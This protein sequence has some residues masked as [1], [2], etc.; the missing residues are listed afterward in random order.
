M[1]LQIQKWS[2]PETVVDVNDVVGRVVKCVVVVVVVVAVFAV[3]GVDVLAFVI[4]TVK[5][6]VEEYTHLNGYMY[7]ILKS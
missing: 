4:A 3:A 6:I 2:V 1:F 5:Q 7:N